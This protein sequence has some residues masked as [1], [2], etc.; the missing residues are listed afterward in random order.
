MAKKQHGI[1]LCRDGK[2]MNV[3]PKVANANIIKVFVD[4]PT[5]STTLLVTAS[6]S[7]R[8]YLWAAPSNV[9]VDTGPSGSKVASVKITANCLG[10][11][12]VV[13]DYADGDDDL[14]VT[15]FYDDGTGTLETEQCT[16]TDIS[17]DDNP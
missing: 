3:D 2:K 6:L 9:A 15:L 10:K 8:N 4:N 17:Y 11:K 7:S 1:G 13:G 5:A 16:F 14:T 12:K